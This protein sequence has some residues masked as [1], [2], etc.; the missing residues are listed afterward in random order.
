MGDDNESGLFTENQDLFRASYQTLDRQAILR[1]LL[2][3][4]GKAPFPFPVSIHLNLTLRCSARCVH[5]KQ[6]TWPSH[7]E[8][9]INQLERL[10]GI[11]ECW[12]VRTITFGGG[13]PLLYDNVQLAIH[14]AHEA[15]MQVGIISEGVDMT[16]E[17][18][19]VIGRYARWMRFS[20]DGPSPDVHDKIRNS[21]GIFSQVM[22]GIKKL[23]SHLPI[24][25]NCVIQKTN[26]RFLSSM[27]DL[28]ERIG[29]DMLLFKIAHGEDPSGRFLLSAG[30]WEQLAQWV[31]VASLRE[32]MCLKTNLSQLT[33]LVNSVFSKEDAVRG[34]PVRSFHVLEQVRCFA[35]FFFL[36]C[37]SEGN[38][39]PCDYLQADTRSWDGKFGEMR[40]G[41]CLGNVLKDSQM[42]LDKL[43]SLMRKRVHDLPASGYSECGSCTRFCQL[44]HSLSRIDS[45]LRSEDIAEKAL[46]RFF[47]ETGSEQ[48]MPGFL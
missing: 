41:F 25:L 39:Y 16:D 32:S 5:C 43:A 22:E 12:G 3:L 14:M 9:T 34:Q 7:S 47:D 36:T 33:R 35:P 15:K 45:E 40:D 38:M 18:A 13:N 26:L 11:F 30:E 1:A 19:D 44:N 10:F 46:D 8:F 42:V 20:L 27:I 37:N 48:P 24:G 4:R 2:W 23:Q 31:K 28:A 6:W 29:V 21:H 17:L